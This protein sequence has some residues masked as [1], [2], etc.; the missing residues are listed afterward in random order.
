MARCAEACVLSL[1]IYILLSGLLLYEYQRQN[2]ATFILTE[3][4]KFALEE[5][6]RCAEETHA[7]ELR[8]MIAN[9]AHD[10]KTVSR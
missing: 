3:D 10:L 9:V 7:S 6:E 4:L 1:M 2:L 8:H 5:R